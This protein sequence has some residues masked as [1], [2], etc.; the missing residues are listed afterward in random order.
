[1]NRFGSNLNHRH[2]IKC[3]QIQIEI[4]QNG[5]QDSGSQIELPITEPFMNRFGSNLNHR[6]KINCQKKSKKKN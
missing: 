4:F 2:I 6:H 3:Q 1:M 5:G